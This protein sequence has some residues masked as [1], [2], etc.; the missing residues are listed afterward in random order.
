MTGSKEADTAAAK[1]AAK[2]A[3]Q[4]TVAEGEEHDVESSEEEEEAGTAEAGASSAA[5]SKKKKK[6]SKKKRIKEALTGGSK[7]PQITSEQLQQVLELNPALKKEV[8]AQTKGMDQAQVDEMIRR[9]NLSE[10]LTGLNLT[11]KNKKDMASHKFWQ[12]Q[13]VPSF[14]DKTPIQQ[15]PIKQIKIEDVDKE[16]PQMYPGFEW[17]TMDLTNDD[18]LKEVYELLSAHYVEDD[19]AMFRFSYSYSFL[20]WALKAPG[21]R[22]DWHVGVRASASNKLVAFISAVPLALRVRDQTVKASEVNFLCVHKK[23][24][25]KRLAPVLIKEI[26]RR[27]YRVGVFQAIY[28]GGTLLPTPV[29]TC[30]YFHRSLNWPK[31]HDVGFS[32]LPHGSTAPRQIAKFKLPAATSIA[33]LRPMEPADVGAVREL[34]SR[35]LART[36]MAQEFSAE[37]TEHWILQSQGGKKLGKEA[38][39]W[40]YVVEEKTEQQKAKG[41]KGRIT[42]FVS[43]YS[44]ESTVI[45]N[46][47]HKMIKAAYLYYYA[48]EAAFAGA[49]E[50]KGKAREKD[51]ALK[52]RLNDLVHDALIL[53]RDVSLPVT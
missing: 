5:A 20:D 22:P 16:P 32:P 14:E 49:G 17:V 9:L 8:E 53:A 39:V 13:P 52:V 25:A 21:W 50:G 41:Q 19:D 31:L 40:A 23:L 34:L 12:T 44:L 27:C 38:V 46:P 7:E 18:E 43:F 11:G 26:T 37:E 42:D 2:E 3:I 1:A 4:E 28:T 45:G 30:R 6:K 10:L 48:S 29:A 24:R 47:K 36:D 15:G 33:G 51:G 35:Y